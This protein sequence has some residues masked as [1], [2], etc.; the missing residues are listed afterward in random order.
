MFP[1]GGKIP[2]R[3]AD[4]GYTIVTQLGNLS[5]VRDDRGKISIVDEPGLESLKRE[6]SIGDVT[7]PALRRSMTSAF[8]NISLSGMEARNVPK[9]TDSEVKTF[10]DIVLFRDDKGQLVATNA[11]GAGLFGMGGIV[12]TEIPSFATGVREIRKTG[13]AEVHEGETI[14]SK[15]MNQINNGTNIGEQIAEAIVKRLN[16]VELKVET[17]PL[18]ITNLAEVE[19]SLKGVGATGLSKIDEFIDKTDSRISRIEEIDFDEKIIEVVGR[20]TTPTSDKLEALNADMEDLKLRVSEVYTKTDRLRDA[21]D[22][23]SFLES[24]LNDIVKDIM[25]NSI[26]PMGAAISQVNINVAS[27][28]QRVV[29]N[30]DITLSNIARQSLEIV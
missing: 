14:T 25:E 15:A 30:E 23:R 19:E 7:N 4:G 29:Y 11:P 22:D 12:H 8:G 3:L 27:L 17:P 5:V 26:V 1:M 16:E 13:V 10:G 28:T 24:R 21:A 9:I 6:K 18:E 20:T 2:Y